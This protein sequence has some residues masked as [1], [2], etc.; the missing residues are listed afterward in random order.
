MEPEESTEELP[1]LALCVLDVQDSFTRTISWP[2][3]YE[4]RISF[5]IEAA[6]LLNI[7]TLFTQQVPNKLG[8][9]KEELTKL[10]GE[11]AS[12]FSKT[13]FSALR[14]P[15][16][17]NYLE[18]HAIHHLLITGLEIPICVY[19]TI[20]DALRNDMEATL[21]TDCSAA[22]RPEDGQHI[23]AS[24]RQH[25]VTCLPSEALFYSIV[26]DAQHSAFR[27]LT[28]LVKSYS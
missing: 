9:A 1:H 28:R 11:D 13:S 8:P 2:E 18:A 10:A 12:V 14:N 6:K 16:V 23:I 7:P 21:L 27:D 17:I 5:A 3:N 15:D 24:L 20:I 19:Q 26:G 25:E 22:R 4:K